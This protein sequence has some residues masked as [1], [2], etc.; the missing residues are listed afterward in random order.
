M[1]AEI[2]HILAVEEES[3][4]GLR[5]A[6]G[7]FYGADPRQSPDLCRIVNDFNYQRLT[8]LMVDGRVFCG[9]QTSAAERY[10]AP[11]ILCEVSPTRGS[12]AS[13][14][15]VRSSRCCPCPI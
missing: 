10:I 11:T 1:I 7:T 13:K 9:G 3:L 2:D 15:S 8:S 14:S 5:E 12:C 6:I 4:A